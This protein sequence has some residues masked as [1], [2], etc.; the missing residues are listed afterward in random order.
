MAADSHQGRDQS[1]LDGG[2]AALVAANPRS[3][4]PQL[5]HRHPLEQIAEWRDQRLVGRRHR[6]VPQRLRPHPLERRMLE[7]ARGP[8]PFSADVKWHQQVK[9]FIRM[10]GKRQ[11]R[12]AG[13]LRLDR[14]LFVAVRG[15]ARPPAF[16]PARPCRREIPTALPA[17]TLRPLADQHAPVGID[18][19]AGNDQQHAHA[20]PAAVVVVVDVPIAETWVE[21]W[22]AALS[23]CTL[24]AAMRRALPLRPAER[25]AASSPR[26]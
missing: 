19:R 25:R 9:G 23:A 7:R 2:G 5:F 4:A 21:P 16:R 8:L 17:L 11:R 3:S 15:S 18:Q 12:E 14:Q 10:A 6:I 13:L 22:P 20:A 26:P 1:I 24:S